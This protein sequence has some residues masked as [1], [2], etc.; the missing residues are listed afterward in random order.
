MIVIEPYSMCILCIVSDISDFF[1]FHFY[2]CCLYLLFIDVSFFSQGDWLYLAFLL[3]PAPLLS[4]IFLLSVFF[5]IRF[6]GL[7]CTSLFKL[8]NIH[9][10]LP[11]HSLD[12]NCFFRG[13]ETHEMN[14]FNIVSF[15]IFFL[16][17]ILSFFFFFA[18]FLLLISIPKYI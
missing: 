13:N 6:S 15:F 3:C 16:P 2:Y 8:S 10:F 14:Y 4:N 17:F 11:S 5:F 12:Q 7:F 18:F 9:F 1:S